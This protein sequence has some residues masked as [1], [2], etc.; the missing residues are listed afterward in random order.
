MTVT[1]PKD[2]IA[3]FKKWFAEA[4]AAESVNPNAMMLAT[5]TVDGRPSARMVLLKDVSDQGFTFYTNLESRKGTELADNPLAALCFYWKALARQVSIEG[6]VEAV[7]D[8]EAD[9]YFASRSRMSR[10]GA[11]ASKQSQPM[12]GRFELEKRV[13]E[14]TAKFHV[15]VVPRPNFWSGFRIVPKTIEFWQEHQFRL[16]QRVLYTRAGDGWKMETLYP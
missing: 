10:I 16:H 3:E 5:C 8:A 11:W 9:E 12:P 13:A 2:P 6:P 4:E 1:K 14:F 7:D 15:G